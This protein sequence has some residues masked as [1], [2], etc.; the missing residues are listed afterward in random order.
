MLLSSHSLKCQL[1]YS[2][3]KL[4]TLSFIN[5]Q[6]AIDAVGYGLGLTD[7]LKGTGVWN[8]LQIKREP[9]DDEEESTEKATPAADTKQEK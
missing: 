5:A 8:G 2:I 6:T 3:A 1:L 7:E 9:K 4:K